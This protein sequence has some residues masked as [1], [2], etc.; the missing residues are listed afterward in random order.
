MIGKY[1]ILKVISSRYKRK[2]YFGS[3]I[4]N[5]QEVFMDEHEIIMDKPGY[6]DEI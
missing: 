3:M 2:R 1:M 4:H 6:F 5:K